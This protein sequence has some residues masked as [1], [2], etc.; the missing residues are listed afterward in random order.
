M[1]V[2]IST[3]EGQAFADKLMKMNRQQRRFFQK[4]NKV[5]FKIVGSTIPLK[6]GKKAQ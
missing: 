3:P 1:P 4:K 6:N 2:P 5:P